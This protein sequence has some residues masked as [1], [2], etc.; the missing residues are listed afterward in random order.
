MV[1]EYRQ[2]KTALA[3][4]RLTHLSNIVFCMQLS[5]DAK[6][7]T[8]AFNAR[9]RK[10]WSSEEK[11]EMTIFNGK[12][13]ARK[14][15]WESQ[16]DAFGQTQDGCSKQT[17]MNLIA[18]LLRSR[19]DANIVRQSVA[20]SI[21]EDQ[22][23]EF[24]SDPSKDVSF[25]SEYGKYKKV[26]EI[27]SLMKVDCLRMPIKTV[28]ETIEQC[29]I[30]VASK[31]DSSDSIVGIANID[32]SKLCISG[33]PV[34]LEAQIDS[35]LSEVLDL[36]YPLTE[37]QLKVY[38]T[39]GEDLKERAIYKR[40]NG[41]RMSRPGSLY[42]IIGFPG[43]GKTSTLKRLGKAS[44][45]IGA[46]KQVGTAWTGIAACNIEG[47]MLLST[48]RIRQNKGDDVNLKNL[49]DESINDM[50]NQIDFDN[51][52]M[53][54]VDEI[55]QVNT[56]WMKYLD[57]RMRQATGVFD[58]P[59][60]GILVVFTGDFMQ[61]KGVHTKNIPSSMMEWAENTKNYEVYGGSHTNRNNA[62]VEM[63]Y[64]IAKDFKIFL[65]DEVVRCS[66]DKEFA[67]F[68]T[69]ISR[70]NAPNIQELTNLIKPLST[71]DFQNDPD[72]LNATFLVHTNEVRVQIIHERMI[73]FAKCHGLP[74]IRWSSTGFVIWNLMEQSWQFLKRLINI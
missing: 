42:L 1:E 48:F 4:S 31:I 71:F 39:L 24:Q 65:L 28:H 38:N 41:K 20:S 25:G 7:K 2:S 16:T 3:F 6:D 23:K 52:A 40:G 26:R 53:L 49:S 30:S 69:K 14:G 44:E 57:Q 61:M 66:E 34:S 47:V 32:N 33:D 19:N 37:K 29:Q 59:F 74:I 70:G 8:S 68:V 13:K 10:I 72:W 36:D 45:L 17:L 62:E 12:I 15:S 55:S 18:N 35:I 43:V 21:T 27:K 11:A 67:D 58:H 64:T 73:A 22:I 5:K 56:K 54:V 50:M 9:S 51:M 60:G 46:G 63:C